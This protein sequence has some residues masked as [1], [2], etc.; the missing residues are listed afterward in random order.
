MTAHWTMGANP[1]DTEFLIEL[2]TFAGMTP[3]LS[4]SGWVRASQ[5]VFSNLSPATTYYAQVK[6]RN[7]ASVETAYADLGAIK[8]APVDNLPPRTA[9]AAG[10]P[11]H[12]ASPVYVA[13][14]T[15]LGFTSEDDKAVEGDGLGLGTARTFFAIDAGS[16]TAYSGT[17]TLTALG[18]HTLQFYS[19]DVL[20]NAEVVRSTQVA[21]D[22]LPSRTAVAFGE[23][24]FTGDRLYVSSATLIEFSAADD[25]AEAGD[26]VGVGTAQ[27]LLSVD[28]AAFAA[29][30]STVSLS[31]GGAHVL[32]WFSRDLVDNAELVASTSVVVDLTPPLTVLLISSPSVAQA[33]GTV[34]GPATVLRFSAQD[35]ASG[36]KDTFLALSTGVF[37]L[38]PATFTL[39]GADGARV[40]EF[41]SRDN[42]LNTEPVVSAAVLLD[43]KPPVSTATIGLPLHVDLVGARYVTPATPVAFSAQDGEAGGVASGLDYVELSVDGAPYVRYA[44]TL[45]FAE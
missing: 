44:S 31:T 43:A 39:T 15:T 38:A 35:A 45:T 8:T 13:A 12:G 19:V 7:R 37:A 27:T 3:L 40:V 11:R 1:V 14:T 28:A 17:F 2:S 21:V 36:V 24:K 25:L 41:Y 20:G 10:A 29:A 5:F 18:T 32:S 6:A 30:A 34:V 22:G 42:V 23:P 16:F 4:S 33:S 26:G 9:F